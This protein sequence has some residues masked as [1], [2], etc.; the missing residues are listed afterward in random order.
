MMFVIVINIYIYIYIYTYM[1]SNPSSGMFFGGYIQERT[2]H[3][4]RE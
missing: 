2:G 3:L 4:R 1:G